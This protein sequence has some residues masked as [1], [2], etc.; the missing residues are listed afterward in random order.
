MTLNDWAVKKKLELFECLKAGKQP[1]FGSFDE[2]VFRE[3]M[4]KGEPQIGATTFHPLDAHFEFIFP[5]KQS[6]ATILT[7]VVESPERI[8][9]LPVP[10]WVVETIWQGD[11]DGSYH[12]E[13]E[14]DQLIGELVAQI[15]PDNNK[16]LFGSRRPS[17][18]E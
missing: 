11:V 15:E 17:R 18:R 16:Q 7:V 10:K 9:F 1:N 6:S 13:S 5:D 12:F 14:A 3:A 8:V 2:A 4:L